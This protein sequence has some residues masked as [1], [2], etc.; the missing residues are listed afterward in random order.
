MGGFISAAGDRPAHTMLD[1]AQLG[2]LYPLAPRRAAVG[3]DSSQHNMKRTGAGLS[4]S[5]SSWRQAHENVAVS[6]NG[7]DAETEHVHILSSRLQQAAFPPQS[8]GKDAWS[9]P[10]RSLGESSVISGFSTPRSRPCIILL[11]SWLSKLLSQ[12]LAMGTRNRFYAGIFPVWC[13]FPKPL[14]FLRPFDAA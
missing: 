8:L 11:R 5:M 1:D 3:R 7:D 4:S 2:S 10:A 13:R 9:L 12:F 14:L 6:R